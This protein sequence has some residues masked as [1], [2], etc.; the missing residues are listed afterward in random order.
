MR[1]ILLFAAISTIAG[2]ASKPKEPP[3]TKAEV[4]KVEGPVWV[5]EDLGGRGIVDSS[6]ADATFTEDGKV[7]G[8]ATCNRFSGS[9]KRAKDGIAITMG[10]TAVTR[11]ACPESLME[12]EGRFLAVMSGERRVTFQPDGALLVGDGAESALF[13]AETGALPK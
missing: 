6:R 1:R 7:Y 12:Q 8:R 5:L 9:W 3:V 11:M 10:P 4:Q 13:R 2:C